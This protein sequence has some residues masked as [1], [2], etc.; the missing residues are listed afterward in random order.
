[1]I[2]PLLKLGLQE[3]GLDICEEEILQFEIFTDELKKWNHKVNL[4]NITSDEDIVAKHLLDSIVIA[5]LI[6]EGEN[7]LDIGSGAG[8]PA[9]PLKIV[10]PDAEIVSVDAVNKKI[11][12]QKHVSRILKFKKFEALHVRVEK[13]PATHAQRF[14]VITSRAFSQLDQ[15]VDFAAPLLA[16]GGRMI[17]MKGPAAIDELSKVEAGLLKKGFEISAILPYFLPL[18]KGERNLIVI[19]SLR[20]H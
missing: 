13:M 5:N 20:P 12:F 7:V 18:N 3:L 2:R 15:F 9:I 11:L 14:D 17:A 8:F 1:M 6:K 19:R 4:T 10:K 16:E